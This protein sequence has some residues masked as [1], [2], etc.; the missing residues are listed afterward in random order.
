MVRELQSFTASTRTIIRDP[1]KKGRQETGSA[2]QLSNFRNSLQNSSEA[3]A[4]AME[5]PASM[6]A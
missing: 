6:G 1:N 5:A 4:A 2:D 3:A